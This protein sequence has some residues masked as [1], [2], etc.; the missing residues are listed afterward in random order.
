MDEGC[1]GIHG[2]LADD[3]LG[4]VTARRQTVLS[5]RHRRRLRQVESVHGRHERAGVGLERGGE[6]GRGQQRPDR[7]GGDT[8]HDAIALIDAPIMLHPEHLGRWWRDDAAKP[9]RRGNGGLI[10]RRCAG[11]GLRDPAV[12]RAGPD[13][14]AARKPAETSTATA[15]VA[16]ASDRTITPGQAAIGR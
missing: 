15:I 3:G 1:A 14:Q 7:V 10:R 13:P 8:Q 11:G 5:G 6:S 2:N 9:Q 12:L 16:G 4:A